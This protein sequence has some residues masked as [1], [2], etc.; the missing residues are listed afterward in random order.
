MYCLDS[1]AIN[2]SYRNSTVYNAES[3][4]NVFFDQPTCHLTGSNSIK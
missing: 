1:T 2:Y 3:N 4:R